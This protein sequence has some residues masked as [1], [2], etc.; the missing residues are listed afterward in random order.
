MFAGLVLNSVRILEAC[1]LVAACTPFA[2]HSVQK[3][4]ADMFVCYFSALSSVEDVTDE[5][6]K[7]ELQSDRGRHS[8]NVS[9]MTDENF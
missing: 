2:A 5:R 9:L 1:D 7:L 4:A 8:K 3:W 6:L